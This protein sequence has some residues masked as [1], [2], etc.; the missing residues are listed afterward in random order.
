MDPANL[1]R[2]AAFA[3]SVS[4]LLLSRSAAAQFGKASSGSRASSTGVHRA[5][6]APS[7]TYAPTARVYPSYGPPYGAWHGHYGFYGYYAY[8]S[9]P[10]SAYPYAYPAPYPYYPP[11][12]PPPSGPPSISIS[13]GADG[14][15]SYRGSSGA[16]GL[17]LAVDSPRFGINAQFTSI[18]PPAELGFGGVHDNIGLVNLFATYSVVASRDARLRLEA[19]VMS[20]FAPDLVAVGPGFGA[21]LIVGAVGPVSFEGSAHFTPYPFREFDSNLGLAVH[22]GPAGIRGGW[23]RI[24][25]DDRGLVDQ[26]SH[27]EV[28]SGPYLGLVF[29]F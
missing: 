23:R 16:F 21:S 8:P 19:G 14:V 11:P 24:W 25:L 26:V 6:P 1:R 18:Y 3:L 15:L 4:I 5:A 17:A 2:L 29:S 7:G 13:F 10:Y 12:P 28:F 22:A 27:Q 20:A 9:E